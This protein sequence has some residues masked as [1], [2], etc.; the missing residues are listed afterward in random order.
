[1]PRQSPLVHEP[2]LCG[3]QIDDHVAV[4][5]H[6]GIDEILTESGGEVADAFCLQHIFGVERPTL[7]CHLGG[8]ANGDHR[9]AAQGIEIVL[10]SDAGHPERLLNEVD[11]QFGDAE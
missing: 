6:L 4:L 11:E 1:M 9:V 3:D 5:V 8:Q 7:L 10:G 2:E